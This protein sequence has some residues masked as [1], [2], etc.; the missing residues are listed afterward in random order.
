MTQLASLLVVPRCACIR[1]PDGRV[2][3]LCSRCRASVDPDFARR[4]D[5]ATLANQ[6][7]R[8]RVN[9]KLRRKP[10]RRAAA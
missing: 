1:A 2:L 9:A 10:A 3:G 7:T 5:P 6:P 4:C 8:R